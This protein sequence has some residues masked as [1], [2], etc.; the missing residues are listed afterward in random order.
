MQEGESSAIEHS[1][2]DYDSSRSRGTHAARCSC[3][4]ISDHVSTAG[5]AHSMWDSHA[6]AL[7]D[8]PEVP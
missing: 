4:W 6:A 8:E 1:M 5:L 7:S 2:A 3:G